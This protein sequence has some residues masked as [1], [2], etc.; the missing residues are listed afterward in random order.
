M[1]QSIDDDSKRS[2]CYSYTFLLQCQWFV[3]V[4]GRIARVH[5]WHLHAALLQ[6]EIGLA[7][8]CDACMEHDHIYIYIYA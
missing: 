3:L 8:G 6:S 1:M 2:G 4:S 5:C 7:E